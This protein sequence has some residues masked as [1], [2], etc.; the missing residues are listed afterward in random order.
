MHEDTL[1]FA[2]FNHQTA[3]FFG[4]GRKMLYLQCGKINN[5]CENPN[6]HL[7]AAYVLNNKRRLLWQA[8]DDSI[9]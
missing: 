4:I 3:T 2:K 1:Y 6:K 9:I 7:P 5:H 8:K